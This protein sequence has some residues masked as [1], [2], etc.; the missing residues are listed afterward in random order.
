MDFI[1]SLIHPS[2]CY[3]FIFLSACLLHLFSWVT[4]NRPQFI[5]SC[6]WTVPQIRWIG[7]LV[8]EFHPFLLI[9][10]SQLCY[11]RYLCLLTI[12][13]VSPSSAAGRQLPFLFGYLLGQFFWRKTPTDWTTR[14]SGPHVYV[15]GNE[16]KEVR[17]SVNIGIVETF[18]QLRRGATRQKEMNRVE[19]REWRRTNSSHTIFTSTECVCVCI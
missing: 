4:D 9:D 10:P 17:W 15:Q 1:R 12:Q 18:Q 2:I 16:I 11:T 13:S 7:S 19:M 5:L 8:L 3:P 14:R 6:R